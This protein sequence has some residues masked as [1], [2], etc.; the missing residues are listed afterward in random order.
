M[1]GIVGLISREPAADC[2]RIVRDMVQS[3]AHERFYVM[4]TRSFPEL[5]IYAGWVAHADGQAAQ[6][7]QSRNGVVQLILAGECFPDPEDIRCLRLAGHDVGQQ[8][9]DWLLP[10]YEERGDAFFKRLNG[11]F[12]GLLLDRRQRRAFL[13]NDRYGIERLYWVESRNK[14]FFASEAK[15][16]L[17]VLPET[18]RFDEISLGQYLRYGCTLNWRTLFRGVQQAQGGSLWRMDAGGLQ[19]GNY[20]SPSEWEGQSPLPEEEFHEQFSETFRQIL[21][22]YFTSSVAPGIALT[23]GLD[24]RMI[25]ACLHSKVEPAPVCYTYAGEAG[26]TLDARVAA[27]V[28]KSCGLRHSLLRIGADFFAQFGELVD[29][30]VYLTDGCFGATGAHEVYLNALARAQSP[31]RVTG[32]FGSEV[33]RGASTFKP[34]TLSTQLFR[35]GWAKAAGEASTAETLSRLHPVTFA[36][37]REVPW[38]IYGSLMACRSQVTFRTPF[39]DN[40]V[41]ALAYRTPESL[42]R[43]SRSAVQFIEERNPSMASI[44]TDRGL[45]GK[46]G[47]VMRLVRRLAAEVT[48]KLDYYNN[49]GMPHALT[50]FESMFRGAN[51]V[52]PLLGHHKFLHY[53]GWFRREL[54]GYLREAAADAARTQSGIWDAREVVRMAEEHIEGTRNRIFDVATVLTLRAVERQ[55]LQFRN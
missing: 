11:L 17:R 1:P 43:T 21:P 50:R 8:V 39:L 25:M 22:A 3:M 4:G 40:A 37:F 33:L 38:N 30:T 55:L 34:M 27:R 26:E 41:V 51:C 42:R 6:V 36:A 28:A 54:A 49:E 32:V 23:G 9:G 29:R 2:E 47:G 14:V 31:V 18:R 53:R 45:L 5:G 16:L 24:T 19:R 48:F 44:A 35:S 7:F 46:C 10:L 13:F 20:F 12:S 52:V 15:A